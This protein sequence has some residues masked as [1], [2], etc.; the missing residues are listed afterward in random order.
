ML[1]GL[2]VLAVTKVKPVNTGLPL[3]TTKKVLSSTSVALK[4]VLAIF[5][6]NSFCSS[7]ESVSPPDLIFFRS[8]LT[9]AHFDFRFEAQCLCW[10]Q[11]LPH[12]PCQ[13]T[14]PTHFCRTL[15]VSL[16]CLLTW[17]LGEEA[18]GYLA[19]MNFAIWY[20]PVNF[21]VG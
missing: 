1:C 18:R 21:L 2:N 7:P 3:Q 13:W 16:L 14:S 19:P 8:R 9:T 6:E 17:A 12:I 4:Q 20:F 10:L 11:Y 5:V 15:I